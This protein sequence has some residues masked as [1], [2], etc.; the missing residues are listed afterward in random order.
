M[1]ALHAY[2]H[3]L[4]Q[5][6][7]RDPVSNKLRYN[8]RRV[9]AGDLPPGVD[10]DEAIAAASRVLKFL[11]DNKDDPVLLKHFKHGKHCCQRSRFVWPTRALGAASA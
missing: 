6:R 10:K 9:F 3:L 11:S 1:N 4:K 8:L 2:R 7:G 5:A